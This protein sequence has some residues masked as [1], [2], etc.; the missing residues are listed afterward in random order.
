MLKQIFK[1]I[2][3]NALMREMYVIEC[4]SWENNNHNSASCKFMCFFLL[5]IPR[6]VSN[7]CSKMFR[8]PSTF[9]SYLLSTYI[10]RESNYVIYGRSVILG[11]S[12]LYFQIEQ[13]KKH[14]RLK[15]TFP[16]WTTTKSDG[17]NCTTEIHVS[18]VYTL[19]NFIELQQNRLI[20]SVF[21]NENFP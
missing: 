19:L 14:S 5:S 17:Y 3:I 21:H 7:D 12:I 6:N 18:S 8:I 15:S 16:C 2:Q 13:W 4:R 1:I 20:W 9:T 10:L 11:T